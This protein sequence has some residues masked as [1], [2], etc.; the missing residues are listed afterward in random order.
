[1]LTIK[2]C[3]LLGAKRVI[4][5]DTVP[6]RLALAREAGAETIDYAQGKV[7]ET[8][9]ELTKGQG[10]DAVIEAVGLESHGAETL[11]QKVASA[12]QSSRWAWSAPTR[13]T[14]RSSPAGPAASCR[15][16]ACMSA[17]PPVPM[18]AFMNKA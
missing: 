10:P 8:I 3:F 5:V 14:R 9:L 11:V 17:F 12:V 7:Q 2:S 13:S 18:G 1:M 16:R 15:C 4:A 6:E